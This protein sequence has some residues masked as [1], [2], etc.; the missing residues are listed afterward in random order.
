MGNGLTGEGS[1]F[2]AL[3]SGIVVTNAHVLGM[4]MSTSLPPRDVL[5]TLNSGQPGEMKMRGEVLGVDRASDLAVVRVSERGL[6]APLRLETDRKLVETQSVYIS[7]FPFGE[8]LG[9]TITL[10]PSAVT[11]LHTDGSGSLNK[12]QLNGGVNPGNSGGPVL[13]SA[14]YVVGVL[15]S[16]IQG[17]GIN[18]AIPAF[19]VRAIMEGRFA[20]TRHGEAYLAGG[21]PRL[22]VQYRCL[23]P[24]NRIKD[25]R[26]EVWVGTPGPE[27]PPM[28]RKP[29]AEAGDG[30]RESHVINY[31]N[32]VGLLDVPLPQLPPGQVYWL[33][34][35]FTSV[36]GMYWGPAQ[37][38]PTN[39]ML[40][41]RKAANLTASLT[42]QKERTT[43]LTSKFTAALTFGKKA[44][45]S[46]ED[47]AVELL[48]VVQIPEQK[49][50]K[51]IAKVKTAYS[52]VDVKLARDG[53]PLS[54]PNQQPAL[55]VVR[56]MPP[57]FVIDDTN[58]TDSYITVS[59]KQG[60]L[61][62][63]VD[64]L[65]GMV[66]NPFE[67]TQFKMPNRV[68]QPQE[69]FQSKSTMML[70]TS[71]AKGPGQRATIVDL[72]LTCTHQ[73]VRTRNGRQE[74]VITI[75]GVMD[76]RM[77]LK[78]KIGGKMTFDIAVGFVSSAQVKIV[79]ENEET[80][81]GV[82]PI[83]E[84]SAQE[85]DLERVPGNPKNL[86]LG[87]EKEAPPNPVLDPGAKSKVISTINSALTAIDPIDP[88]ARAHPMRAPDA[89]MKIYP[90]NLQAGKT[91]VISMNS[92]VTDSF[93]RL[94]DS[95][96]KFITEDDD[97][98][99]FPNALIVYQATQTG[100]HRIIAT[101]FDGKLGPYQLVVREL[102]AGGVPKG[103]PKEDPKEDPK[104]PPKGGDFPPKGGFKKPG[105]SGSPIS[106][107]KLISAPGD[108]I[109]QGKTYDYSGE[110]LNAKKS[111]R[112][113]FLMVD[114]WFLDIGAPVGQY[115]AVGEYLNAK[116]Y[117]S[118]GA[119]P[120]LDFRGK[121]RGSNILSGEF[122]V[123]ELEM[124]GDQVVRL[125]IDFVQ[126]SEGR[127]NPLQGKIRINSN[128]E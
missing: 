25:L 52:N 39:L 73:G 93:L 10:S 75:V 4:M 70:R 24:L 128:F 97:G 38:T 74:A 33:Q 9:R 88:T 65:N 34:P 11:N 69:E 67:A 86:A 127:P 44:T 126:R 30:P 121:G 113:I 102:E 72:N 80:I 71:N 36:K 51:R 111:S 66:H 32:G 12:I 42:A 78:G 15:V 59:L 105:Q 14:G 116:R 45:I 49:G 64:Q 35:V 63:T 98:G 53:K 112:G 122:V 94:E 2:F 3:E 54:L 77:E 107:L 46:T 21:Q 31:Q 104:D 22:P 108:F 41:D 8:S 100:V 58:A 120:G 43:R 110:K 92:D 101:S 83:Q 106:Y 68:V 55:N 91:Y 76:G 40:L 47:A 124:N 7:G 27:R 19:K 57:T 28:F 48:E 117:T 60:P 114:G 16:G 29:P 81:P 50:G 61:K 26:V 56:T 1:G 125:A 123:W 6:P 90:Q 95:T 115:L 79:A 109:G 85:I 103:T 84:I 23:D 18:F 99:G 62:I 96:G 118:S 13:N 17:A 20:D 119:A 89:R 87:K 82:G 37:S 5:V